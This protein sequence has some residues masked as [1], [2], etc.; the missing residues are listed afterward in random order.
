M[1]NP[2][3]TA[4]PPACG[5]R[6]QEGERT[7]YMWGQRVWAAAQLL[8]GVPFRLHGRDAATGLDCVGVVCLAYRRAGWAMAGVPDDYRLRGHGPDALARWAEQAGLVDAMGQPPLMGDVALCAVAPGQW[9]AMLLG[10]AQ[11]II[12]AHAGLRRVVAAPGGPPWPVGQRWRAPDA[13][14]AAHG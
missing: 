6:E 13:A 3:R 12:H 1:H 5:E 2:C 8:V 10:G 9:H 14:H 7:Q 4:P 11:G